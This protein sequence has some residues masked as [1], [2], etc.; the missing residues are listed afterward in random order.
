MSQGTQIARSVMERGGICHIA[1]G[2]FVA[3]WHS[4]APASPPV[5]AVPPGGRFRCRAVS[6][7]ARA[8]QWWCL[9]GVRSGHL[10]SMVHQ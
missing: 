4:T 5:P 6:V 9:F 10:Y 1:T 8:V 7:L 2:L 3:G